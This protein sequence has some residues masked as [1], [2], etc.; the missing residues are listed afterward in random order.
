MIPVGVKGLPAYSRVFFLQDMKA[1]VYAF[2]LGYRG[3]T[4]PIS[5]TLYLGGGDTRTTA[6]P[7]RQVRSSGSGRAI[8][9][10]LFLPFGV[11]WDDDQWFTGKSESVDTITKFRLPEGVS[12]VERKGGSR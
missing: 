8:L 4:T 3:S 7:V 5:G 12:W 2:S 6:T 10:R 1:G 11:F 9:A